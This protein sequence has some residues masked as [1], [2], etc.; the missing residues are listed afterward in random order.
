MGQRLTFHPGQYNVVGTPDLKSFEQTIR[1]LSHYHADV[2]DLMG[3]NQNSVMVVHGG[4]VYGDK[5]KQKDRWCEQFKLLPENVQ[6]RLVL[7][8]CERCFSIKDCLDIAERIQNS[9]SIDTHHYDCY[10]KLHP[11]ESLENPEYYIPKILKTWKNRNIKPRFHVSEQGC[12][13]RS[14]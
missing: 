9:S 13:K 2:L 5:E 14:S 4:G 7:E 8:N 12:G 3:C 1:D 11:E 10:V 6:R